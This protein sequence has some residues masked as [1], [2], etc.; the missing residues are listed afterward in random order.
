MNFLTIIEMLL[1]LAAVMTTTTVAMLYCLPRVIP[2][3]F[4]LTLG[5]QK[6]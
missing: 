5:N 2:L 6:R 1:T 3:K 4:T